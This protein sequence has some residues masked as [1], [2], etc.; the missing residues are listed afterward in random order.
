M[1]RC[2]L[3]FLIDS[4]GLLRPNNNHFK[5]VVLSHLVIQIQIS[6]KIYV[7]CLIMKPKCR[8]RYVYLNTI[9]SEL[10]KYVSI[11]IKT[12]IQNARYA[13]LHLEFLKDFQ[14]PQAANIHPGVESFS[15]KPSQMAFFFCGC[16]RSFF[17]NTLYHQCDP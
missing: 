7:Y 13:E 1:V 10:K 3:K 2:N 5:G 11:D 15:I 9:P 12:Q 8:E 17:T 14:K 16:R 6:P 4:E